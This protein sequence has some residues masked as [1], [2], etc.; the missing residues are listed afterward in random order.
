MTRDEVAALDRMALRAWPAEETLEQG[1]WLLRAARGVTG[2]AN[3]C[4]PLALEG[5]APVP[6][7]IDAVEAFYGARGLPAKFYL[8]PAA[9]P[10]PDLLDQALAA[11]GYGLSA[12]THV[13][14]ASAPTALVRAR[15]RRDVALA[16]TVD[17]AWREVMLGG[18]P[19]SEDALG[20]LAIVA[21]TPPPGRFATAWD[22]R[23]PVAVGR[24]SV[25]GEACGI[26]AMRTAAHARRRGYARAVLGTLIAWAATAGAT[27]LYLQV[28]DGND[29]AIALYRDHGFETVYDYRYRTKGGEGGKHD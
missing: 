7:R 11:R 2:R 19:S 15:I 14:T 27:R 24:A 3:S 10:S 29:G 5:E 23:T 4:W 26:F 21:R 17:D 25:D 28:E 8:S 9:M 18:T 20:R 22:G 12:P 1:G 6:A 13:M 16:E